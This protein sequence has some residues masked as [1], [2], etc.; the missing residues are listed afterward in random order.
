M[1]K[2]FILVFLLFTFNVYANFTSKDL[3]LSNT[4]NRIIYYALSS[5]ENHYQNILCASVN[6]NSLKEEVIGYIEPL[7]TETLTIQPLPDYVNYC[8][9]TWINY[10]FSFGLTKQ[11]AIYNMNWIYINSQF[12][13]NINASK[14]YQYIFNCYNKN[15]CTDKII[16]NDDSIQYMLDS[17]SEDFI[18]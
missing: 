18:Y 2:I 7:T 15:V 9:S 8:S 4:G 1:K 13:F 10:T 3:L 14:P 11:A 5:T 17:N 12:N 6:K 16:N